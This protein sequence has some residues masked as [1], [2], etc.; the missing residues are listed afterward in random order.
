MAFP[1][2]K[3]ASAEWSK[4][5]VNTRSERSTATRVVERL[6]CREQQIFVTP[7]S[8][9]RALMDGLMQPASG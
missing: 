8:G 5:K 9:N 4:I 7:E 3:F 6:H 1:G 2:R